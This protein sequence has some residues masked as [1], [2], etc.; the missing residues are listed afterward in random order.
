MNNFLAGSS[1]YLV[2]PVENDEKFG[3]D[4][5]EQVQPLLENIKVKVYNPLARPFWFKPFE[6]FIP[7]SANR[8]DVLKSISNGDIVSN[9]Y[10]IAQSLVR[11]V[12][13]RYVSTCD[14][15]FAYISSSKTYGTTEELCLAA[16]LNKPIIAVTP[17]DYPSLWIYD[18]VKD[19]YRFNDLDSAFKFIQGIDDGSQH[20]DSLKWI[21]L[22]DNYEHQSLR[23]SGL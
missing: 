3:K 7:P 13:L 16:S 4:W 10:I 14:F 21:F 2:G 23:V 8:S 1:C 18:I 11:K 22:G 19:H 9:D 20:V 5:R 6:K 15:V 17:S 12:C